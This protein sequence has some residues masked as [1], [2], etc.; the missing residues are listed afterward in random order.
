MTQRPHRPRWT[1][2]PPRRHRRLERPHPIEDPVRP[3]RPIGTGSRQRRRQTRATRRSELQSRARRR[4]VL[5]STTEFQSRARRRWV[6]AGALAMTLGSLVL[7]GS[8]RKLSLA[9]RWEF[10]LRVIPRPRRMVGRHPRQVVRP[11][12]R[13]VG[14][15]QLPRRRER[16]RQLQGRPMQRR[17]VPTHLPL[18][19]AGSRQ[20]RM[21]SSTAGHSQRI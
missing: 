7:L 10:L 2:G 19:W 3:L 5:A 21:P 17:M 1:T 14:Q 6:P 11:H 12:R 15:A 9:G 20:R 13:P 16:I 4:W 18:I 8:G